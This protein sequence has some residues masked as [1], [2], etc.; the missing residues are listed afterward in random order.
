MG[1]GVYSELLCFI[2]AEM[3]PVTLVIHHG[4][5][6]HWEYGIANYRGGST[7]PFHI[8]KED[9]TVRNLT[10]LATFDLKYSSL[11]KL[12]YLWPGMS[13]GNGIHEID[14]DEDVLDGLVVATSYGDVHIYMECAQND[15]KEG[16]GDNMTDGFS[17]HEVQSDL[18]DSVHQSI[19]EGGLIHLID[20]SD[21]TTDPKFYEAMDKLGVPGY[22][23][24][25]R[26]RRT[27]DGWEVSQLYAEDEP[28][29]D[30]HPSHEAASKPKRRQ[31]VEPPVAPPQPPTPTEMAA[32]K[33]QPQPEPT[34]VQPRRGQKRCSLCLQ[35][36][37]NA[38][39]CLLRMGVQA[40]QGPV[41]TR[42]EEARDVRQA[43]RGH[44]AY[45]SPTTGKTYY[46]GG[47]G[48]EGLQCLILDC[49]LVSE[50]T[51]VMVV[52]VLFWIGSSHQNLLL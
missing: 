7:F 44:G 14:L 48:V 16:L 46:R 2:Y 10:L 15:D 24:T 43:L 40:T 23:K 41:T 22:R 17:E 19:S 38:R 35:T 36:T 34:V 21:R 47:G 27:L 32:N 28:D 29:E 8:F 50:L 39:R 5:E 25:M 9:I 49:Y 11:V 12:W 6:M 30:D 52:E 1:Y 3:A 18:D 4:G 26:S 37:H 33:P 45:V 42:R 51:V 31:R 20:D 13:M